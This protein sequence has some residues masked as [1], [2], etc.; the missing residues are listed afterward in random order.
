VL[1]PG[2][3]RRRS[4]L[5]PP[6]APLPCQNPLRPARIATAPQW[7]VLD[8]PLT[9][10]PEHPSRNPD[11]PAACWNLAPPAS[12]G[13]PAGTIGE[14]WRALPGVG[15]A[16]RLLEGSPARSRPSPWPATFCEGPGPR[17]RSGWPE[18]VA[19]WQRW[20][21]RVDH[22]A[23]DQRRIERPAGVSSGFVQPRLAWEVP[24]WKPHA[25][26]GASPWLIRSYRQVVQ[27]PAYHRL[28]VRGF[29]AHQASS[30]VSAGGRHINNP[31]WFR[32]SFVR[33][34]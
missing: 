23:S 24:C 25:A 33:V 18:T 9:P 19:Q 12:P 20:A 16:D 11:P 34:R 21:S 32:V 26:G 3:A 13:G 15:L 5:S 8:R 17:Q 1:D 30:L 7:R 14:Q 29:G 10:A 28:M 22:R 27:P 31:G 2:S 4:R 6:S